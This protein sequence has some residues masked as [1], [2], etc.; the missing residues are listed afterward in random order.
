MTAPLFVPANVLPAA[1]LMVAAP[2]MKLSPSV[3]LPVPVL[4]VTVYVVP[5]PITPLMAAP[6]IPDGTIAKSACVTP[7]TLL[8]K[9]TVNA[10][11]DVFVGLGC[12]NTIELT[13]TGVLSMV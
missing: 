13:L 9:V 1:S 5:V 6:L 12:A 10:T 11:D 2:L 8:L 3:P 7:L 4:A